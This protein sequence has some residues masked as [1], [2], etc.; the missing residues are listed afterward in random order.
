MLI[1][2]QDRDLRKADRR[3]GNVETGVTE[4]LLFNRN[5][6]TNITILLVHTVARLRV[7]RMEPT[8]SAILS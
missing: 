5:I 7:R 8:S 3:S 6:S 1:Q 4:E 2:G